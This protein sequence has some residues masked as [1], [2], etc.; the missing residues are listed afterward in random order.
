MDF[1]GLGLFILVTLI[2]LK[3]LD[4]K[5]WGEIVYWPKLFF[6]V[7]LICF[8]ALFNALNIDNLV[9]D[10][11]KKCEIYDILLVKKNYFFIG[12]MI[13]SILLRL[14]LPAEGIF[15]KTHFINI[16][17]EKEIFHPIFFY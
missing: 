3:V 2:S 7:S 11:F 10:I 9:V 5:L 15:W 8:S 14:F 6:L 13:G 1:V 4:L 17:I 12:I 16:N